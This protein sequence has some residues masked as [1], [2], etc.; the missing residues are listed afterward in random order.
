MIKNII[1]LVIALAV[2]ALI[3]Y[4]V[5][6][7]NKVIIIDRYCK[8]VEEYQKI[9]NFYAK[10]E[11]EVGVRELWRKD[12]IG[13]TKDMTKEAG[14]TVTYIKDNELWN[15][16]EDTKTAFK[17]KSETQEEEEA[18]MPV[19]ESNTFNV[20][21]KL[22]EKI[23]TAFTMKITMETVNDKMCYKFQ[24]NDNLQIY[25]NKTDFMKIKEVSEGE[26][27]QLLEY[28]LNSVEDKDVKMPSL[29][30]Y[31]IIENQ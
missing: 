20:E 31:E 5:S 8:K 2:F 10:Y 17:S 9:T 13:M 3:F 24:V 15:I 16:M 7:I 22:L 6:I 23:K 18:F 26:T 11:D 25:V 19:I 12:N 4:A 21:D 28:S 14:T 1:K 29:E 27:T 30:G